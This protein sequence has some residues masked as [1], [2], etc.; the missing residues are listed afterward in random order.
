MQVCFFINF[1]S[2]KPDAENNAN[3]DAVS[4]K[5]DSFDEMQFFDKTYEYT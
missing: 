2:F 3:F 4:S 1:L 5:R